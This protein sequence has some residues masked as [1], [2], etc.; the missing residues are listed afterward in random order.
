MLPDQS[1][2]EPLP[3]EPLG[4]AAAWLAEAI[5]RR[6]QPNPNAMV[7]A[8]VASDGRPAGRIV[9]CKEIDAPAGVVRFVTNYDSRK[10]RELAGNPRA[11][12]VF[13]WDHLHR[14]LR[15]EGHVE[16]VSAADSDSYF[17]SRAR[18]S[19]LGAHASA[20]SEPVASRAQMRARLEAVRALY[21][22]NT[23]VPRPAHWG[24]YVLR[25]DMVELWVEG[26]NRVHDRAR[27]ARTLADGHGAAPAA[28]PWSATRLQP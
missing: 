19:Q 23:P 2:P 6:D 8:T 16:K 12:L 14:Q 21:P 17:A 28:G 18:D 3:A 27:W 1:L 5:A 4:I 13:H 24:G 11:A 10:G 26:A 9:L 25:A 7:L 22:G 20:Q 15:I